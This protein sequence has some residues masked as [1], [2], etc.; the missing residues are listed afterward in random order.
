[1]RGKVFSEEWYAHIKAMGRSDE[2]ADTLFELLDI[3]FDDGYKIRDS[4]KTEA[5]KTFLK[6]AKI[7]VRKREGNRKFMLKYR[8]TKKENETL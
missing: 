5:E 1:M 8:E 3:M 7:Q 4:Y 6:K 2:A